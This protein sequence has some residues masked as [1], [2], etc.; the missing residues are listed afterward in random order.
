MISNIKDHVIIKDNFFNDEVY[1]KIIY[2]ISHTKFESRSATAESYGNTE[3][4][5]KIYFFT[6]LDKNHFAVQEVYKILKNYGF[7]NLT[8]TSLDHGYFLSAKHKEAT[9]HVDGVDLNCLVYLKGNEAINSGTGFYDKTEKDYVLN[10]HI[11]F[12]ENRAI[13][14]DSKI[15][16]GS[17]QFNEGAGPRYV[18]SNFFRYKESV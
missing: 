12:R 16:H 18:M 3:H 7:N 13:I 10:R 15:L 11:G 6:F 4:C 17:L 5:Q 8:S 1:K 14:F 2:D 9:P